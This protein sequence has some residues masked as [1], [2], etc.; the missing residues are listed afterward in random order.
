MTPIKKINVNNV[1][2]SISQQ[3]NQ[4]DYICLT[5]MA[6][7]N[8]DENERAIDLIKSWMKTKSTIEFLGIWER[9]NNQNF[10][11]SEFDHFKN[12]AGSNLF[13]MSPT[14]WITGVDAIGIVSKSGRYGGTYAHKDIAYHFGMWLSPEF[15]LLVVKEYQRLKD[16]ESNPLLGEW[17]IKRI[18]SKTNYTIHTDAIKTFVI[19]KIDVEKDKLYAYAN[20][21][22][23]LNIALWECSA[24]E[25]RDANPEAVNKNLNIRD[26][27]SI[28]ELI[29]LSNLESYNAELIKQGINDKAIRYKHLHRMAQD[30]LKHLIKIN[31]EQNFKIISK[32]KAKALK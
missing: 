8:K 1:E 5:D 32:D 15:N 18:L 31:A 17:N 22:D 10:K 27:A 3:T 16:A 21:A 4:E 29:V 28:N 25:W 24:K 13:L 14:K 20:E 11:V 9:L 23:L 6:G 30:Q 7:C 2:I 12:E 26:M 19:P